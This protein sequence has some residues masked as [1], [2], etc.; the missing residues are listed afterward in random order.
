[1][2]KFHLFFILVLFFSFTGY[3]QKEKISKKEKEA[4]DSMM[5]NDEFVKMM[6]DDRGSS[7]DISIGLGNSPFSVHNQ[8][9]NTTGETNLLIITPSVYYHHKSGFGIGVL[10][11]ISGDSSGYYQT[12]IIGSYDYT[13]DA[14]S[15]GISYTRYVSDMN[16]YNSKSLYQNDIYT[17]IKSEIG[18]AHV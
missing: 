8:T 9:V 12:G 5:K 2:I 7:L 16:K 13:G 4:L 18:R 17:Y 1:M 11:F 10:P 6:N 3:C 15:A 14:V